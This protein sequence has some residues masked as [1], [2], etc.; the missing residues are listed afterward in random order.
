MK[1]KRFK[2][3]AVLVIAVIAS[4]FMSTLMLF[5][6]VSAKTL[7]AISGFP[8][9]SLFTQGGLVTF[10][11]NLKQI[12][13]GKMT[14]NI[15]GPDVIPTNE[16][17]QPLQAGVFDLLFTHP[18]YHL[19][20]TAA[21][22]SIE[23]IDPDPVKRR[24]SGII[25]DVDGQYNK[26]GVKLVAVLPMA[27]YNIVL[28]DPVGNLSPSLKGLKI[29]TA[30]LLAPVV[31]TL[32]GAPV[33][34]PPGEIY[35]SLQKGVIDGFTLVAV[36]LKDYKVHEVTGYLARPLFAFISSSIFMNLDKYNALSDQEKQWISA[37]AIKSE[38]DSLLYFQKMHTEEVKEL[39]ALGMKETMLQ[40]EDAK[41]MNKIFSDTIWAVSEKKSGQAIVD[42]HKMALDKGM[43]R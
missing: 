21:G 37:T 24:Q 38:K 18:A 9:T 42:L 15:S 11:E 10:E 36:G 43:T 16:Q 40:P 2:K 7:R 6:T 19:G 13:G 31:K 20:T 34:I 23:A 14:L 30:S 8:K 33:N 22:A 28:K 17:F 5:E 1:E 35:T 39:K 41:K 32:G 3:N 4:V 25:D 27:P 26:I 12:S 29:R